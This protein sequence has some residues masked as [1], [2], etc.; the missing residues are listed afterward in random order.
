M[1]LQPLRW[2]KTIPTTG[3]QMRT[4]AEWEG[5]LH[6]PLYFSFV[7][8][9]TSKTK[10]E[11]ADWRYFCLGVEVKKK[12]PVYV[13]KQN[14]TNHKRPSKQKPTYTLSFFSF[15][16]LLIRKRK[17]LYIKKEKNKAKDELVTFS[18]NPKV[19]LDALS[20]EPKITV[21]YLSM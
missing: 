18:K 10:L 21:C 4:H 9:R 7:S 16:F 2:S 6:T 14:K 5:T 3:T 11:D 13:E 8:L 1:I 15:F 19:K 12:V 17:I 20:P